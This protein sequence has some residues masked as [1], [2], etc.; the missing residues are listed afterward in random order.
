MTR[1]FLLSMALLSGLVVWR[2]ARRA[3]FS[4]PLLWGFAVFGLWVVMLPVYI[5][6]RLAK[7]RYHQHPEIIEEM[8]KN[9]GP[10]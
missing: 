6:L 9:A 1:P 3:K 8:Q 7:R 10:D 2:D 4:W 5:Y